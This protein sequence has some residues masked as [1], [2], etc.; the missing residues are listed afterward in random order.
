[1]DEHLQLTVCLQDLLALHSGSAL[2]TEQSVYSS[3]TMFSAHFKDNF[4]A[5]GHTKYIFTNH[6]VAL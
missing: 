6:L 4:F 1:M 2:A 3:A 5:L